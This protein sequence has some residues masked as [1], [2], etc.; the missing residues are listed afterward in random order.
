[1]KPWI[2]V[3]A[4]SLISSPIFADEENPL[5]IKRVELFR[6]GVGYFEHLGK[7]EGDRTVE[8]RFKTDQVNDVL[9][10]LLL[11]DM[12]GG[13]IGAVVYPSKDPLSKI[14]QSFQVDL[15]GDPS[16]RELLT[17]VRGTEVRIVSN[18]EE[19][20]GKVVGIESRQKAEGETVLEVWRVNLL[21]G[22]V[23]QSFDLE[24]ITSLE[25]LDPVLQEEIGE[26][27]RT[28]SEDRGSDTKP[29]QISFSGGGQR[30]VR[31]GYLVETPI[32]K[33]SYRLVLPGEGTKEGHLQGWA[34]VENQT[35]NDWDGV[36]LS[37]VSGRPI[38]FI[39]DL[40]QPLYLP[41]PT[42]QPDLQASLRPQTYA[43][44]FGYGGEGGE[45]EKLRRVPSLQQRSAGTA[46]SFSDQSMGDVALEAA[47]PPAPSTM[48]PDYDGYA[49]SDV[50][51][52]ESR[53][54]FYP[55]QFAKQASGAEV[56]E[57]FRF[58]VAGVTLPRQ[59]SAMIPIV[60]DPV[61]IERLS[62]FNASVDTSHPLNGARLKNT[63]GK[64]L[65]QGPLTVF[66][67]NTYAGDARIESIPLGQERLISYALDLDTQ[68]QTEQKRDD[69]TIQTLKIR[70]G[71][72]EITKKRVREKE[73]RIANQGD[74]E[75][76]VLI[77]HPIT[78]GW[79]LTEPKEF[80]EKTDS[81][82]RFEVPVAASKTETLKVGEEN[83]IL[84]TV[85]ILSIDPSQLSFYIRAVEIS[86]K[87]REALQKVIDW[88]GEIVR[89]D[90]EIESRRQ[91]IQE[92]TQEQERIRSNMTTIRDQTSSYYTRLLKKLD[93][94]ETELENLRIEIEKFET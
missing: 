55:S 31:V 90:R 24:Q 3:I 73:Y 88:K 69:E 18:A 66:D 42:V 71:A 47:P 33:A 23:L 34:I 50:K 20:V 75:R 54:Y 27:L 12:D 67:E 5:P 40:Y 43:G 89:L 2:M 17:Q 68:V 13:E 76:V 82:Y 70:R 6:S 11:M 64:H 29:I 93:E 19:Y 38:S 37:L 52:F 46:L 21:V 63:S 14:M 44:G 4:L 94:Q 84:Q 78:P 41:R 74:S 81:L 83:H 61:D 51:L 15:S 91:R 60:N 62:I 87:L 8:L 26:A 25:I 57:L 65:L 58:T 85:A 10:S 36:E 48:V 80:E 30:R 86:P 79:E 56:G 59:R 72:L 49:E 53:P 22:G 9:K 32:W 77:E 28:L 16:V 39:Q 45:E 1:M 7:V 92:I 35:D